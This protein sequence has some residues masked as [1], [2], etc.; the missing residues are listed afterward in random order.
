VKIITRITV[1]HLAV[2]QTCRALRST[3]DDN[4]AL[5]QL[6]CGP[7]FAHDDHHRTWTALE[8][9]HYLSEII[10][11]KVVEILAVLRLCLEFM[12]Q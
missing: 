10:L 1:D 11:H 3:F 4:F 2:G 12:M 9:V 8:I 5:L 7:L 6:H